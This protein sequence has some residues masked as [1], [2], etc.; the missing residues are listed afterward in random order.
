MVFG[1]WQA[2]QFGKQPLPAWQEVIFSTVWNFIF[3]FQAYPTPA[4]EFQYSHFQIKRVSGI[5]SWLIDALTKVLTESRITQHQLGLPCS[6]IV[7]CCLAKLNSFI[8]CH[9]LACLLVWLMS[10]MRLLAFKITMSIFFKRIEEFWSETQSMFIQLCHCNMQTSD[11]IIFEN[12]MWS[13]H[14]VLMPD[15]CRNPEFVLMLSFLVDKLYF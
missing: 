2:S 13:W 6:K 3:Q 9:S 10:K 7:Y 4:V 14:S 5:L 8:L 11:S 1:S 12:L 15:L